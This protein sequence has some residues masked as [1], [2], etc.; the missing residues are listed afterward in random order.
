MSKRDM[1]LATEAQRLQ[2]DP[3]R[4]FVVLS[5]AETNDLLLKLS[6]GKTID[7]FKEHTEDLSKYVY[8]STPGDKNIGQSKYIL[9]ALDLRDAFEYITSEEFGGDEVARGLEPA[10]REFRREWL[11]NFGDHVEDRKFW[12]QMMGTLQIKG[13]KAGDLKAAYTQNKKKLNENKSLW[14]WLDN[15]TTGLLKAQKLAANNKDFMKK[16]TTGGKKYSYMA[17]TLD[18]GFSPA[19]NATELREQNAEIKKRTNLSDLDQAYLLQ[20]NAV[21]YLVARMGERGLGEDIIFN[22]VVGKVGEKQGIH[23]G[24]TM[25][26]PTRTTDPSYSFGGYQDYITDPS[27]IVTN[28]KNSMQRQG[29]WKIDGVLGNPAPMWNNSNDKLIADWLGAQPNPDDLDKIIQ[30]TKDTQTLVKEELGGHIDLLQGSAFLEANQALVPESTRSVEQ[31][32]K[33]KKQ[34]RIQLQK[35]LSDP[36][37]VAEMNDF[38][39]QIRGLALWTPVKNQWTRDELDSFL[40]A[41]ADPDNKTQM[42]QLREEIYNHYILSSSGTKG[43][44]R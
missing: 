31:F 25:V 34:D 35:D 18:T 16:V 3:L 28:Y 10:S 17:Y 32:L 19:K 26:A 8:A 2:Y 43:F 23:G 39:K 20:K 5:E 12:Y 33:Q 29:V 38:K 14:T 24:K 6:Q 21:R 7:D 30:L 11:E 40:D 37:V 4:D 22:A 42:D 15:L 1:R 9:D 36:K 44:G 27:I 13:Q 41:A